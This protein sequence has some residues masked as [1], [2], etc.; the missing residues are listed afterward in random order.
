MS[1][2]T[3]AILKIDDIEV[4][5]PATGEVQI[6]VKAFGINRAE[7]MFRSHAYL[8]EATFPSRLG[9]EAAGIVH[10]VGSSVTGFA[11][12]DIVSIVPALDIAHEGTYGEVVNVPPRLVVKHPEILSFEEAAAAWM[13]YVTAWGAFVEQARLGAADTV[14]VTAASSSVGLAAF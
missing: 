9:Y 2:A 10:A 5:E 3:P 8:Q 14:I 7:V 13:Q 11:S 4:P 12:G 1:M 6:G